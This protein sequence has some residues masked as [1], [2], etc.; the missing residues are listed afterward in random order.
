[1]VAHA[2]SSPPQWNGRRMMGE[3]QNTY[4]TPPQGA[5]EA[6]T[7]ADPSATSS[8]TVSQAENITP[9]PQ[10]TWT[11]VGNIFMQ[12]AFSEFGLGAT[13]TFL[14][15]LRYTEGFHQDSVSLS[16]DELCHGKR[17]GE[18][19]LDEG[20]RLARTTVLD[21]LKELAS[22]HVIEI[23]STGRGRGIVSVYRILPPTEWRLNIGSKS[24]PIQDDA[25]DTDI[26]SDTLPIKPNIGSKSLPITPIIGSKRLPPLKKERKEREKK[27]KASGIVAADE[28]SVAASR[29]ESHSVSPQE[30]PL[31]T[32]HRASASAQR[33]QSAG[34]RAL[35]TDSQA[36][37]LASALRDAILAHKPDAREAKA[38]LQSDKL[39]NWAIPMDLLLRV[40]KRDYA[41][42]LA[43]IAFATA[44]DFWRTNI[45]SP[46]KFREQWDRLDAQAQRQ[47]K[48]PQRQQTTTTTPTPRFAAAEGLPMSWSTTASPMV[49][50][51]ARTTDRNG[52]HAN[53]R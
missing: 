8:Q 33:D 11:Q 22:K 2:Y 47:S 20:T 24:L 49:H 23:T 52:G 50:P 9:F 35:A 4:Q 36:V 40:D 48:R 41:R 51:I 38:A 42:T 18:K 28:T 3:R 21:G 6:T 30:T 17:F 26:G 45:L 53:G 39:Q 19:R 7:A 46:G 31:P 25:D 44:D 16:I 10:R 5:S 29:D 34:R 13:R 43:L 14:Y 15:I 12:A 37:L 32:P 27:E 1:M